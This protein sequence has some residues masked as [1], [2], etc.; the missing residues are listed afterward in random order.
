MDVKL[1]TPILI[2]IT[3]AQVSS[4]DNSIL[5]LKKISAQPSNI[6]DSLLLLLIGKEKESRALAVR[7]VPSGSAATTV[8]IEPISFKV[9]LQP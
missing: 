1:D 2:F 9:E 8:L 3:S 5:F 7:L 6:V 4:M